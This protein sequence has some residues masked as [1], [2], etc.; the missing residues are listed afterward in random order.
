M[1]QIQN[2][3]SSVLSRIR[4]AKKVLFPAEIEIDPVIQKAMELDIRLPEIITGKKLIKSLA[5]H[6]YKLDLDREKLLLGMKQEGI[7]GLYTLKL[8]VND[9]DIVTSPDIDIADNNP[10]ATANMD[11]SP[12]ES[13]QSEDLANEAVWLSL[14]TMHGLR[15]PSERS[16]NDY[17]FQS[18]VKK[19]SR[20]RAGTA[21][22]GVL[23]H[24]ASIGLGVAG[25]VSPVTAG[26]LHGLG[27]IVQGSGFYMA[28]TTN[29]ILADGV[30]TYVERKMLDKAKR[31][32]V[33]FPVISFTPL[34]E[35]LV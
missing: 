32:A 1:D 18:I 20:K 23:S 30:E 21:V 24:G 4:A 5:K 9:E 11:G 16:T 26:V 3:P 29:A 28:H 27:Y 2:E 15:D 19:R 33:D 31:L 10:I 7:H 14:L 8:H 12:T 17:E 22:A 25:A 13:E 34:L 6:G 35:K